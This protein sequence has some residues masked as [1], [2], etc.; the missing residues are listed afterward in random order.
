MAPDSESDS[1]HDDDHVAARILGRQLRTSLLQPTL[2]HSLNTFQDV[3]GLRRAVSADVALI[4]SPIAANSYYSK[5]CIV[6]W[7][8]RRVF[9]MDVISR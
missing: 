8:R 1:S 6:L 9:Q 7:H 2:L 5:R 3:I 4:S